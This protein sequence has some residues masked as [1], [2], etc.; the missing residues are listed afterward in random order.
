M[1]ALQVDKFSSLEG[2]EIGVWNLVVC[3]VSQKQTLHLT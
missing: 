2:A 1:A 3:G